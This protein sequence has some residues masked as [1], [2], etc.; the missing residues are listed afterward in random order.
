MDC[1]YDYQLQII[2][3]A[4]GHGGMLTLRCDFECAGR[5]WQQSTQP[6]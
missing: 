3:H 4:C 5:H 6:D 1:G 2:V